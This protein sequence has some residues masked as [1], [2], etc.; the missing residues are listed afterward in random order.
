MSVLL[1]ELRVEFFFFLPPV[2]TRP[3][4]NTTTHT[5]THNIHTITQLC[6]GVSQRESE[7][8]AREEAERLAALAV[9]ALAKS[10]EK[11]TTRPLL[12]SLSR[13]KPKNQS[14]RTPQYQA[15]WQNTSG[16]HFKTQAK[17]HASK[18]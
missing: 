12:T 3:F 13:R 15:K 11:C 16:K 17:E 8:L 10:Q 7:R 4:S 9:G 14:Q 2:S 18:A 6:V 5:Y 1:G